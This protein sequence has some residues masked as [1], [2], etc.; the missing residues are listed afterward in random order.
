VDHVIGGWQVNMIT[1]ARS[2]V[3]YNLSVPGDIANT[4]DTGYLRP[5]LVGNATLSNPTAKEYFNT[6]AF[7]IPPQ[8]TFGNLGRFAL[9][10]SAFWDIDSSLFRDFTFFENKTLEFR[11]E[12]FNTP[13]TKIL[14]NPNGNILD[15]NFGVVTGT[16][17]AAR[18]LQFAAKIIF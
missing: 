18:S 17:N 1:T 13:N 4:G 9:R 11:F 15:P 14:G 16:A 7:A 5:N 8:Y 2:G 10:G 3:P 6:A 12:S